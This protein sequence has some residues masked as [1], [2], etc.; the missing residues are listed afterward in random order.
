MAGGRTP[1]H[2]HLLLRI[3]PPTHAEA[4]RRD[5]RHKAPRA[6]MA[7]PDRLR[8]VPRQP[9]GDRRDHPPG[10]HADRGQ[11]VHDLRLAAAPDA[12]DLA[13][14]PDDCGDDHTPTR[15]LGGTDANG[16][17]LCHRVTVAE[18]QMP[19]TC[20]RRFSK[21]KARA[22]RGTSKDW[23]SP[24]PPPAEVELD[25]IPER[26]GEIER[27]RAFRGAAEIELEWHPRSRGRDWSPR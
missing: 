26:L 19:A 25:R 23:L 7:H 15:D 14:H 22:R 24:P 16:V 2:R 9:P 11:A 20:P 10:R 8:T 6:R 27:L 5:G 17:L 4:P 21:R 1:V 12:I 13:C 3:V 18:A